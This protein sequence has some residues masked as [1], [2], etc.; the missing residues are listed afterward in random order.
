MTNVHGTSL[1]LPTPDGTADAYLAHPDDG[2]PHPGVLLYMDA[3]GLRPALEEMARRLA[4]HGY[5]VLVPNVFHRA[6]RAPVVELPEHINPADRPEIFGKLAPIMQAVT[7]ELAMRD[8]GAYLDWL[9]AS[10][11]VT[12]GP[13]GTTG[14][15]MG[16]V[17]AVR[18]AAAYPD[19]VAAA[20]SFHAGRL[21]TDAEDSPHRLLDRVTA[22]LYFGHAD[23][24]Q[25]MTA[26]HIGLLEQ[27]LDAAGVRYRSERYE[28][29]HHGYTQAD[30][31]MYHAEADAR[32][33]QALLELLGRAL[34]AGQQK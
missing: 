13:V 33:W 3:F 1:D 28:G 17:L 7:P 30:T 25:S 32:H 21:V 16:G 22:E 26:E 27:A 24:D 19:R 6:G 29:A 14:Y 11:L 31:A 9:A 5:T 12:D 20:A 4:G 23:Q 18:T 2:A 15:C 8:A 10:P 34:P